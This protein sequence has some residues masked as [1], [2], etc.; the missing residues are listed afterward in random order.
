MSGNFGN[1]NLTGTTW[2]VTDAVDIS[3]AAN[4]TVSFATNN[5]FKEGAGSN[6]FVILIAK[7]YTDGTSPDDAGITW[8]DVTADIVD[9][10]NDGKVFGNDGSF[11]YT[12][13]NLTEYIDDVGSDKFVL[14]FK[15]TFTDPG[16]YNAPSQPIRNGSWTISDVRY[17]STP[18]TVSNGA[19]SALNTSFSGQENIFNTPTAAISDANFSNTSKWADVL[20]STTSVPRLANGS[21]IPINEGYLF[22]VSAAYNPILVTEVRHKLANATSTKGASGDSQWVVQASNDGSSWDTVSSVITVPSNTSTERATS[23]T[24]TQEYRYYRFVLSTA[25][26]PSQLYT[27]LQQ[28]DFTVDNSSLSIDNN[29]TSKESISVYPNPVNSLLHIKNGNGLNISNVSLIDLTGKTVYSSKNSNSID[30]SN[31]AKG[32]YIIKITSEDGLSTTNKVIVN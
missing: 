18:I 25:W 22:E 21:L 2:V 29:N 19:F 1:D 24:T 14:A 6:P 4:M 27:A 30:V 20:T 17:F 8:I 15:Y 9:S 31:L 3:G 26:T 11:A 28:L 10:N 5:E 23:L 7:N 32:I 13:L 12:T 16:D